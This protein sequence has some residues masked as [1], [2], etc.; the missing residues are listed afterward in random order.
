MLEQEIALEEL[1]EVHSVRGRKRGGLDLERKQRLLEKSAEQ[2][3]RIDSTEKYVTITTESVPDREEYWCVNCGHAFYRKKNES[4]LTCPF[5]RA[6]HHFE[7]AEEVHLTRRD[8]DAQMKLSML[9][10]NSR[11][12]RD[13]EMTEKSGKAARNLGRT[14]VYQDT[15]VNDAKNQI[16][17]QL[18]SAEYLEYVEDR[19][20]NSA[21]APD[22]VFHAELEQQNADLAPKMDEQ[23]NE[24]IVNEYLDRRALSEAKK[25]EIHD[26]AVAL[27]MQRASRTETLEDDLKISKLGM[28]NPILHDIGVSDAKYDDA[29]LEYAGLG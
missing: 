1:E 23:N 8:K 21:Q 3:H 17:L 15:N 19:K 20:E 18:G 7:Q 16:S 28:D 14:V 11:E 29:L 4:D 12:T 25:R 6:K 24:G 26:E 5:C 2:K 10:Q 9:A 13:G 27:V 22:D